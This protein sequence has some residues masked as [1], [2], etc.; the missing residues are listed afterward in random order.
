ML[1]EMPT[2]G[3]GCIIAAILTSVKIRASNEY[4]FLPQSFAMTFFPIRI[5]GVSIRWY[6]SKEAGITNRRVKSMHKIKLRSVEKMV[7]S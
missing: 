1:C 3:D 4:C 2:F 6:V 5:P 7:W